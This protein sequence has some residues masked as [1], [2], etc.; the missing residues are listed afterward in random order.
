MTLA[1]TIISGLCWTWV[2]IEAG[3]L[4]FK[5]KSYA[6]PVF[7]LALNFAWETVNTYI[8]FAY[9][10][11]SGIQQLIE[12][13]WAACDVLIVITYFRHGIRYWP[14]GLTKAHFLLGSLLIFATGFAIQILFVTEFGRTDGAKDA[15]FLQN[16]L[17]SVLFIDMLFKR[18]GPEGQSQV[19]AVNKWIGTAAPTLQYGLLGGDSFVL[20]IGLLCFLFDVSYILLLSRSTARPSS[21][22]A[23]DWPTRSR[24]LR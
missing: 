21:D 10:G 5:Q 2:Y 15:A 20:G 9:G 6:I 23:P 7:A 12:I 1:L 19:I 22:R 14:R 18:S 16:L 24:E 4:G 3:R 11:Q 17:M 8:G 13:V